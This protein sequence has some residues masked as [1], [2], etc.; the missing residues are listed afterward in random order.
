MIYHGQ[1]EPF[2]NRHARRIDFFNEFTVV[3]IT[4]FMFIY[5]DNVQDE[6]LKFLIGWAQ[7]GFFGFII[8]VNSFFVL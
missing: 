2:N 6:D 1:A 4:Y 5:N 7:T 3:V 8:L